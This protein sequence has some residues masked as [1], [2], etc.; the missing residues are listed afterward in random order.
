[1]ATSDFSGPPEDD[2]VEE[3]DEALEDFVLAYRRWTIAMIGDFLDAQSY[4]EGPKR[5][6]LEK[7]TLK[8][9][10]DSSNQL[11]AVLKTALRPRRTKRSR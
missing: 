7:K 1:M 2:G 5:V 11:A 8:I 4:D 6:A 3:L 10:E 9:F